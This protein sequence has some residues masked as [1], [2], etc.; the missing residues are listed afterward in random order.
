MTARALPL[1]S[2]I[3]LLVPDA[4]C[5]NERRYMLT[6]F[7]AIRVEG[8]FEVAVTAGGTPGAV[9]VADARGFDTIDVR[10]E[11]R[12]LVVRAGQTAWGGYPGAA[13]ASPKLRV[14]ARA[15]RGAT[16]QGGGRLSVDH[17]AGQRIDLALTGAG[18]IDVADAQADQVEVVAVGTGAVKVGGRANRGRFSANGAGSIDAGALTLSA[19][20]LSW[21][22]VGEARVAV[23][24]TAEIYAQGQGPVIVTGEPACKVF[25]VGPVTCGRTTRR[26]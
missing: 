24:Y 19:L 13:G 10:V 16:V 9:G 26:P 15:L 11:S 8:P 7:D 22:S 5:A 25:G 12:T 1:L 4:A 3:T 21:Q 23:R 6:D 17:M 2:A 18:S 20:W 14:T